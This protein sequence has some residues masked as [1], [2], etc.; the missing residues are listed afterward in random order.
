MQAPIDILKEFWGYDSFRDKQVDIIDSALQLEDCLAL[1]PTGG[2]KSICY[3]VPGMIMNGVCLVISPLIAL[4]ED[5]VQQLNQRGIRAAAITSAMSKRQI[6]I[7]LDN[8]VYGGLKFLYVSPERLE[9]RIFKARF[10]KMPINLIAVDEAHCISEWGYDFRPSYIRIAKLREIQ[11]KIPIMALTATATPDV[12][13]D[14]QEKLAFHTPKVIQRSFKRENLVY[15]VYQT[16]NKMN[17]LE[18]FLATHEGSGIIYCSTRR[19]TKEV[20]L[21]LLEKKQNVDFYH[22]GLSYEERKQK[23]KDWSTGKTRV[24]IS[25]NAFGMGID[26][27]NV[28]FVLHY[29][30][31][32]SPEAY[33]QEAGR[34]G[35]DGDFAETF[36][37]YE[38]EDLK[39]LEEKL[40]LRFPPIELIKRIYEALGNHF[41]VAIGAGKD[42]SYPIDLAAFAEKYNQSLLIV[43]NALKFL[44]LCGFIAL[45]ENY[46]QPSQ[47]KILT[48]QQTLYQFQVKDP[49][50][51]KI[52]LFI[53]RTEMGVFEN[54][55]RIHEFKLAQKT[56]LPFKTIV[57]KLN[58][59]CE[60]EAIDYIPKSQHPTITY[61]TE[62][63]A[64]THFSIDPTFYHNRKKVAEKKINAMIQ[65]ASSNQCASQFLLRYFGE[66]DVPKC[67]KCLACQATKDKGA[68]HADMKDIRKWC[69]TFASESPVQLIDLLKA[70]QTIPEKEVIQTL[71][72]LAEQNDLIFDPQNKTIHFI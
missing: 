13:N 25:T 70:F 22:A 65:M 56:K 3:Q 62:R 59:L 16:N 9:T 15:N 44:E 55:V 30:L 58:Y 72:I 26:K 60:M 4:M 27:S 47:L 41:Q 14:I 5:Q 28:R 17:R 57:Q 37:F 53:L 50:L 46:K 42:T 66:K 24:I 31:P 45:S 12:V 69:Q 21:K 54:Y 1:L 7:A 32:Q 39:K 10:E 35:R 49:V 71:R 29:D 68:I 43:Y 18:H 40:N 2:G 64:P 34:A 11:P 33:F 6:D 36:L 51:N 23:Q 19:A 61:V 52:I 38:P 48:D 67:G 20:C 8:A 63:L